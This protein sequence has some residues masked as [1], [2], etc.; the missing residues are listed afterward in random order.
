MCVCIIQCCLYYSSFLV[1]ALHISHI[2]IDNVNK[3]EQK[4][5]INYLTKPAL[6]AEFQKEAKLLTA[7]TKM[8]PSPYIVSILGVLTV[9]PSSCMVIGW[10]SEGSLWDNLS[11]LKKK[12]VSDGY[13][14]P[15]T[16]AMLMN[17]TIQSVRGMLFLENRRILHGNL[18]CK[19]VLL[20]DS[21]LCKLNGIGRT[22]TG[23]PTCYLMD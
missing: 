5:A 17:Y 23:A 11:E 20:D 9:G 18:Q 19:N 1:R 12:Q 14:P 3:A 15:H 13:K 21:G 22:A 2:H 4:V 6:L 10:V 16:G 8:N 7:L